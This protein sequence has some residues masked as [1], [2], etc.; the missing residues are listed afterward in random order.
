MG[1][2]IPHWCPVLATGW[3]GMALW[4]REAVLHPG[5]EGLAGAGRRAWMEDGAQEKAAVLPLGEERYWP[6]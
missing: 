5:S 3:V 1:R 4:L 2:C 6:G